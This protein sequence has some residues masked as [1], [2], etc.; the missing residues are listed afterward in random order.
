MLGILIATAPNWMNN[1]PQ[2]NYDAPW[3]P[4]AVSAH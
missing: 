1:H 4:P 3:V 2:A